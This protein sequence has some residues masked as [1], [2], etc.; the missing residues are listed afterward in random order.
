MYVLLIFQ[1]HYKH[2]VLQEHN[3]CSTT[4]TRAATEAT[5]TRCNSLGSIEVEFYK[6]QF[7]ELWL[8][9]EQGWKICKNLFSITVYFF[10]QL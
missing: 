7:K 5:G 6:W 10:V 1:W 2:C 3:R 4:V 8:P 9:K